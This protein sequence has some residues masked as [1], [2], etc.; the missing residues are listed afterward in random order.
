[1]RKKAPGPTRTLANI[2]RLCLIAS[3]ICT[4][5]GLQ[6][7]VRAL[8]EIYSEAH[9][10][11]EEGKFELAQERLDILLRRQPDIPEALNL[12]G[13]VCDKIGKPAESERNF[14]IA[15]KL[16]PDYVEARKNLGLHLAKLGKIDS[17]IIE[18]TAA[19]KLQPADLE[20]HYLLGRL[21]FLNND[22]E[23]ALVHLSESAKD[24]HLR[25]GE[26]FSMLSAVELRAGQ[27]SLAE[28]HIR[29]A[30]RRGVVDAKIQLDLGEAFEKQ[31]DIEKAKAL[32]ETIVETRPEMALGHALL[33]RCYQKTG[34]LDRAVQHYEKAFQLN[35][36]SQNYA[37][38]LAFTYFQVQRYED[39]SRIL[40]HRSD[41]EKESDYFNLIGASYAKLGRTVEA[42][43]ALEKAIRLNPKDILAYYNLG[44]VLLEGRSY[45]QAVRAFEQA[46][47]LFPQSEK[48]LT[49]LGFTHQIKGDFTSARS[50]FKRMAEL[51]P[52]E[53]APYFYLGS[54]FLETGEEGEALL[55]LTSAKDRN[56]KDHRIFYLMGLIYYN[57]GQFSRAF[58]V[59][60]T[61]LELDPSFVF[62]YQQ[63]AKISLKNSDIDSALKFALKAVEIDSTFSQ[64]HYLLGQIYLRLHKSEDANREIEQFQK[65]QANSPSREYRVF[66]L[67]PLFSNVPDRSR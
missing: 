31:G 27:L 55:A 20:T 5:L 10:A 17:A 41:L 32:Y 46:L 26:L 19:L 48:L 57:Q 54:S 6:S 61:S 34:Q 15:I 44:L 38:A 7:Q 21:Y 14:R 64:P 4:A 25:T 65:L 24:T 11:F 1:M 23:N 39:T 13:V 3:N 33:A 12:L 16:K 8:E 47:E 62:S 35:P 42:G 63:L 28:E 22:S 9:R 37:F 2:L 49:A 29:E 60:Q 51:F 45:D 53:S 59:F 40:E 52:L 56:P 67:S 43:T 50:V 30:G 18:I 66:F 36:A 58:D